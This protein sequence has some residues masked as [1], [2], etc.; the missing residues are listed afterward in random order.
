MIIGA[1]GPNPNSLKRLAY[2]G[3][4]TFPFRVNN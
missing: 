3:M 1:K 2:R 4:T